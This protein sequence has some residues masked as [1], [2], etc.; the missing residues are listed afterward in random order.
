MGIVIFLVCLWLSCSYYHKANE[1][2][3]K[4]IR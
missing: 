1:I 4:I 3:D 2:M